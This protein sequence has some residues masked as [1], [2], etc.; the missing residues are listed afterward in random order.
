VGALDTACIMLIKLMSTGGMPVYFFV[1]A[2]GQQVLIQLYNVKLLE[3]ICAH[4]HMHRR[5]MRCA[6]VQANGKPAA[7]YR[8]CQGTCPGRASLALANQ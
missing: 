5:I 2:T 7:S 3:S 4:L 1:R 6:V 8:T